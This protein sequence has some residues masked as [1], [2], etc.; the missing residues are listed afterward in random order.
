MRKLFLLVC[1]VFLYTGAFAQFTNFNSPTK[2]SSL[3]GLWEFKTA[4]TDTV[5]TVGGESMAL[6]IQNKELTYWQKVDGVGTMRLDV[7][8]KVAS[9]F[10]LTHGLTETTEGSNKVEKYAVMYDLKMDANKGTGQNLSSILYTKSKGDGNFF[11]SFSDGASGR[12]NGVGCGK[13]KENALLPSD[14]NRIILNI[15]LTAASNKINI[16]VAHEDGTVVYYGGVTDANQ[17]IIPDGLL[18]LLGDNHGDNEYGRFNVSQIALFNNTLTADEIATLTSANPALPKLSKDNEG[19]WY[20]IQVLGGDVRVGLT[21]TADEDATDPENVI[22]RVFGKALPTGDVE[23]QLWR[24]EMDAD[25]NY[26]FVNKYYDQYLSAWKWVAKNK[27][28][29]ALADTP[30]TGWILSEPATPNGRAIFQAATPLTASSPYFHQGNSGWGYSVIFETATWGKGVNS[31]FEFIE[32]ANLPNKDVDFGSVKQGETATKSVIFKNTD[33]TTIT[34]AG[35]ADFTFVE[36]DYGVKVTY[37]PTVANKDSK[38]TITVEYEGETV[39][40]N[41]TGTCAALPID[42]TTSLDTWYYVNWHRAGAG[43]TLTQDVVGNAAKCIAIDRTIQ[44]RQIWKLTPVDVDGVTKYYLQ[45]LDGGYLIPLVGDGDAATVKSEPTANSTYEL[46]SNT[47]TSLSGATGFAV[48]IS[49]DTHLDHKNSG[50]YK[51]CLGT[52]G[53]PTGDGAAVTFTP[54][55]SALYTADELDFATLALNLVQSDPQT[56]AILD[57]NL[58]ADATFTATITG[59]DAAAFEI[60]NAEEVATGD[61]VSIVFKPTEEKVYEATLTITSGDYTATTTL[62]GEGLGR[63][64]IITDKDAITFGNVTQ[65]KMKILDLN[66]SGIAL[67]EGITYDVT[68]ADATQFNVI[69]TNWDATAGENAGGGL[70]ILITPTELRD[71]T[72]TLT[73]TTKNA[74]ADKVIEITATGAELPELPFKCSEQSAGGAEYWYYIYNVRGNAY[75]KD[76]GANNSI[77]NTYLT[78][79]DDLLWKV[80]ESPFS[81]QYMFV[82]KNNN[83]LSYTT[84]AI[85]EGASANTFITAT[86]P[87]PFSGIDAVEHSTADCWQL[88]ASAIGTSGSYMNKTNNNYLYTSYGVKNDAGNAIKFIAQEDAPESTF[89]KLSDDTNEYWYYIQFNRNNN[90]ANGLVVALDDN[91]AFKAAN[92]DVVA[93]ANQLFKISAAEEEGLYNI[94]SKDYPDHLVIYTDSAFTSTSTGSLTYEK[95]FCVSDTATTASNFRIVFGMDGLFGISEA[96]MAATSGFNP[97][98]GSS[99]DNYI[100]TYGITDGGS[101]LVFNEFADATIASITADNGTV[102]EGGEGSIYDYIVTVTT[103]NSVTLTITANDPNA[104]VIGGGLLENLVSGDNAFSVTV[105][106]KNNVASYKINVIIPSDDASLSLLKLNIGTLTPEFNPEVLDYKC[107]DIPK[108]TKRVIITATPTNP[109][110]TVEGATAVGVPEE[111]GVKELKVTVTA[112]NGKVQVYTITVDILNSIDAIANGITIN[113][114]DGMLEVT[115]EGSKNIQVISTS[116]L[117]IDQA[118][119]TARYAKSLAQGTYIVIIDGT[120]YKVFVK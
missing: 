5:A 28:V 82:S 88:F 6:T 37:V 73:L 1:A 119:A 26:A 83:F 115:F 40:V 79:S 21:M 84:D 114:V 34:T 78:D 27:D 55:H 12:V 41:I 53:A 35:D 2:V 45:T 48:I 49:G 70:R 106:N 25:G 110:A 17:W 56:V 58:A 81:N 86:T 30:N 22:N 101:R 112:Q 43:K 8:A 120:A 91:G 69:P 108:G 11:V 116:G 29:A 59:E 76:A 72:A 19:P 14:W 104:T 89:P 71:Y 4:E 93:G 32:F 109:A 61:D 15:D 16:Y 52:W 94:V 90:A 64:R 63:P 103:G 92:K 68:G 3:A 98:G 54:A 118:N 9:G 39:I 107:N 46:R 10:A 96:S 7:G 65:G 95:G 67:A 33:A 24:A 20:F 47:H 77:E 117:S 51:D 44:E 111:G 113:A 75:I 102:V 66:V 105:K 36:D 42:P 60:Q 31:Q 57:V 74:E 50:D 62:K 99:V 87:S 100:G 13:Y 18:Y 80:Y 23:K 85:E 97:I 38:A